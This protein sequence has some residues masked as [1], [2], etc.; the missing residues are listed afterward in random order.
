MH[1]WQEQVHNRDYLVF[2]VLSQFVFKYQ[3]RFAQAQV[4]LTKGS[5]RVLL[6]PKSLKV[7]K[8]WTPKKSVC[9]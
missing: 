6:S 9:Y 3:N 7:T 4:M 8:V 1:L 5:V 2:E